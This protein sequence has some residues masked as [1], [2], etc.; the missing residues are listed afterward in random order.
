MQ[1]FLVKLPALLRGDMPKYLENLPDGIVDLTSNVLSSLRTD[2]T[3]S[4]DYLDLLSNRQQRIYGDLAAACLNHV[5]RTPEAA[6]LLGRLGPNEEAYGLNLAE[7]DGAVLRVHFYTG[8]GSLTPDQAAIMVDNPLDTEKYAPHN[9]LGHISGVAQIGKLVHHCY[10]EVEG[11]TYTAGHMILEEVPDATKEYKVGRSIF[12]QER[13]VGLDLLSHTEIDDGKGYWM[14]RQT[15]HIVT[16]PK[17]TVTVFINDFSERHAS[18]IY[19][20]G[21]VEGELQKVRSLGVDRQRVWD[22]F[23][24]LVASEGYGG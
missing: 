1:S 5:V 8:E 21:D 3:G 11:D 16:W 14:N 20:L 17:P 18:T 2:M 4:T 23:T 13:P 22:D 19:Q 9:H 7:V 24:N 15:A 6:Q 10:K 12:V